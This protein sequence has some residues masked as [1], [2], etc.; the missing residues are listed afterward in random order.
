MRPDFE[1]QKST[2]AISKYGSAPSWVKN[3][4]LISS[5]IAGDRGKNKSLH[6]SHIQMNK[7][8]PNEFTYPLVVEAQAEM[9]SEVYGTCT[10]CSRLAVEQGCCLEWLPSLFGVSHLQYEC[11]GWRPL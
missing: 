2:L 7:P 4:T 1:Y 8:Y 3:M 10:R 9:E 6:G 11:Q 5:R